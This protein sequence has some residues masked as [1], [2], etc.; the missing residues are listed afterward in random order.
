MFEGKTENE[1]LI[2]LKESIKETNNEVEISL[3]EP[4]I[5]ISAICNCLKDDDISVVKKCLDFF[6][7]NKIL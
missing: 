1:Q 2:K 4:Q 7:N 5:V 3:V 6:I